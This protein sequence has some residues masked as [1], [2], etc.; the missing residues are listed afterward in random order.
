MDVPIVLGLV[1]AWAGSAWATVRGAG[2]VYFDAIAMLVFFVLLAR[3]FETRA[4]L[5]AAAALDR[6]AVVQPAAARRVGAGASRPRSP[7]RTFRRAI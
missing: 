5:A 4:R 7:P 1:T 3:A 2:P 6:L